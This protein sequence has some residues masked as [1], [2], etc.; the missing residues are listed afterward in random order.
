MASL[1]R[2]GQKRDLGRKSGI[3]ESLTLQ[4]VVSRHVDPHY[5]PEPKDGLT[6][7]RADGGQDHLGPLAVR[8]A[9]DQ[10]NLPFESC[11]SIDRQHARQRGGDFLRG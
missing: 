10:R 2:G 6:Q 11:W 7:S 9:G 1:L 8:G 5:K 3:D 4:Q